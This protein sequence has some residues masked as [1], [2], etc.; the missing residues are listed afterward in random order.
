MIM[1]VFV[2]VLIYRGEVLFKIFFLKCKYNTMPH[3]G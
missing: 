2:L 1:I 3:Y